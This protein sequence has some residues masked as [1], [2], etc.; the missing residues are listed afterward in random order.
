[1]LSFFLLLLLLFPFSSGRAAEWLFMPLGS[2]DAP[3]VVGLSPADIAEGRPL[4]GS[5]APGDDAVP[6][7]R[8]WSRAGFPHSDFDRLNPGRDVYG[9]YACVFECP[10]G[11]Q[12]RDLVLY[13]GVIDD[14]D[15][16]YVNGVEVG[17]TGGYSEKGSAW[18]RDREYR[19][20]ADL[21]EALTPHGLTGP[22]LDLGLLYDA[23]EVTLNG[24]LVGRLGRLPDRD[25]A[26]GA[27]LQ[28]AKRLRCILPA[29]QLSETGN[30]LEVTAYRASSG[31]PLPFTPMLVL[32]GSEGWSVP[33]MR[34]AAA[35]L[36]HA[37]LLVHV[38]VPAGEHM[39]SFYCLDFDWYRTHHPRQQS[40]LIVDE[41]HRV[42]N[43]AWTGTFG[44]G[45]YERF[46]VTGPLRLTARFF[47]HRSACAA[48]S[49]VFLDPPAALSP[50]EPAATD[51][52]AEAG[53]LQ[54]LAAA[55]SGGLPENSTAPVDSYRA[56]CRFFA[57][58][59]QCPDRD[60]REPL[61]YIL[62]HCTDDRLAPVRAWA[63]RLW[64]ARGLQECA[65]SRHAGKR[66]TQAGLPWSPAAAPEPEAETEEPAEPKPQPEGGTTK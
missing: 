23:A 40:V 44:D 36:E 42:L 34:S 30:V 35:A 61:E 58:A 19:I 13:L 28:T 17:S 3:S 16:A 22:V 26:G 2:D 60:L 56:A 62:R 57:A 29:G 1:L 5:P 21:R 11:A 38:D 48:V 55:A 46:A 18:N 12:D 6:P 66:L 39:L 25:D 64:T 15:I 7:V 63:L 37:D 49:G 4:P 31:P 52:S 47:K 27:F 53:D 32:P 33:R 10:E 8:V 20:P 65:V 50:E 59:A 24:R 45:V 51:P 43:A 9:C 14:A 54:A 41:E